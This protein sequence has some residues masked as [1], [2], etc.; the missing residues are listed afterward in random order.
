MADMFWAGAGSQITSSLPTCLP[1]LNFS[2]T[3]FPD[4]RLELEE[5]RPEGLWPLWALT[6]QLIAH[7]NLPRIAPARQLPPGLAAAKLWTPGLVELL[8]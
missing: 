8:I 2:N 4:L 1:P 6:H 5:E 7:G 3:Q